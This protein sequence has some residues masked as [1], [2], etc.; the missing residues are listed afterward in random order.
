MYVQ[1][2]ARAGWRANQPTLLRLERIFRTLIEEPLMEH[3]IFYGIEIWARHYFM[4]T[5]GV[6][7]TSSF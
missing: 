5:R 1:T 2:E 6:G 7:Q 4:K 3:V